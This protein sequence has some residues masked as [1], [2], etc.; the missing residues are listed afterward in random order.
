MRSV[1]ALFI[2]WLTIPL[3][4]QE[5]PLARGDA[6]WA[7]RAEGQVNGRAA[8]APISAAV[9]AY[10]EALRR[11]PENLEVMWKLLRAL[12]FRGEFT[13]EDPDAKQEIFDRGRQVSEAALDR[14]AARVSGRVGGRKKLDKMTPE[15][16]CEAFREVPEAVPIYYWGGVHWGLWGEVFGKI[17]AARQGVGQRI[18]DY[19]LVVIGL[20]PAEYEDAGGYRLLGRLHTVAPKIP[21]FTG[22]INR[23]AAIRELRRAVE[24][25]PAEPYNAFYLADALLQYQ[26]DRKHEAIELLR[27]LSALEPRPHKQVEDSNI[28]ERARALL[29]S[30]SK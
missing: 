28:R 4:G 1:I 19:S 18:R 5:D 8:D 23:E 12:Y 13:T 17:A 22:W 11:Q 29:R 20:A 30:V 24:I 15:E 2:C 6:A 21:F 3:S 25:G 26:K 27:E 14:L 16:L 9:A 10:E 7:R